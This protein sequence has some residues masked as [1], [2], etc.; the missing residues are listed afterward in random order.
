MSDWMFESIAVVN[1][2]TNDSNQ[3]AADGCS[4]A[5]FAIQEFEV[6][7]WEDRRSNSTDFVV[8]LSHQNEWSGGYASGTAKF[9]DAPDHELGAVLDRNHEVQ[10][11]MH[12]NP[13]R[14]IVY[15]DVAVGREGSKQFLPAHQMRLGEKVSQYIYFHL[16][17]SLTMYDS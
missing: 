10:V 9:A 17:I 2:E 3:L 14:I 13:G 16:C 12:R 1:I 7:A 6:V 11:Q 4:N 8:C 15:N 5:I